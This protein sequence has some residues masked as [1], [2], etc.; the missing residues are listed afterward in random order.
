MTIQQIT[1]VNSITIVALDSARNMLFQ[2]ALAKF[3]CLRTKR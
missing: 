3:G 2:T 1:L